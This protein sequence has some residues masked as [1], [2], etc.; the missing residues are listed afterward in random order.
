MVKKMTNHE[1]INITGPCAA[2]SKTQIIESARALKERDL[3][4]MRA[5]WWKPRTKPGFE[6]N[7]TDVASWMA[8]VTNMGIT[9]GTEVLIPEHV[10]KVI[11]GIDQNDGDANQ[12]LLWLGSRNQNHII[13]RE[14]ATR[15]K[16]EATENVKLLIKNQPWND[17][18]H[19]LGVVDH[20]VSAGI[21]P[22]RLILC[23]RGFAPNGHHNPL[24]LRNMPDFEMAMRVK[25]ISGLPMLLDPSHIGGSVDN[26]F[27]VV[28]QAVDY[29]F[30]GLMVEVHPCPTKAETDA[31][32]QLTFKQLDQLLEGLK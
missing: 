4:N 27:K 23:H 5:S 21:D 12:V 14:I 10:T 32:Q 25:Q 11:E 19:W 2:E 28:R 26:V 17:E 18:S 7:G 6:G 9:I 30:D 20:I 13:Q 3:K 1:R 29:D 8:E 22:D 24:N 31:K 15:I 16:D